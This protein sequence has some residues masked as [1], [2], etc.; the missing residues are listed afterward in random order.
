MGWRSTHSIWQRRILPTVSGVPLSVNRA[1][2]LAQEGRLWSTRRRSPLALAAVKAGS[3]VLDAGDAVFGDVISTLGRGTD[4]AALE[5]LRPVDPTDASRGQ[6][7]GAQGLLRQVNHFLRQAGSSVEC[8]LCPGLDTVPVRDVDLSRLGLRK[9]APWP[10]RFIAVNPNHPRVCGVDM[11]MTNV[12]TDRLFAWLDW[13]L[14]RSEL[15]DEK[16]DR[17]RELAALATLEAK[18]AS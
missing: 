9:D 3:V 12:P 18:V 6:M 15:L 1:I 7:G 17:V 5:G 13:L 8:R 14:D 2:E 11:K 4:L 16:A 10:R